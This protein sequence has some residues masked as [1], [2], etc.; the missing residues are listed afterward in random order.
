MFHTDGSA[1][2]EIGSD[3]PESL[4]GEPQHEQP[5]EGLIEFERYGEPQHEPAPPAFEFV[6][7]IECPAGATAI[8]STAEP[9]LQPLVSG[10]G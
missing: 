3:D 1:G 10:S 9:T 2:A 6:P 4:Y 8:W 5:D 7:G